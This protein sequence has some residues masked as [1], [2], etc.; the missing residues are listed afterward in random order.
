MRKVLIIANLFHAS[1]RIPGITNYLRDF[2]W[3]VTII[4][5]SLG[6]DSETLLGF[7]K[8]NVEPFYDDR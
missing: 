1:P 8:P 4:S 5:P 3:R 2:G 6:N 7:P